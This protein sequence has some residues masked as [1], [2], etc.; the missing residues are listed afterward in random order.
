MAIDYDSWLLIGSG[1]LQERRV[2]ECPHCGSPLS[3]DDEDDFGCCEACHEANHQS[4]MEITLVDPR[5]QPEAQVA[6][7]A[8]KTHGSKSMARNDDAWRPIRTCTVCGEGID[9]GDLCYRHEHK[10]MGS[11]E[12]PK[13]G[14]MMAPSIPP[15]EATPRKKKQA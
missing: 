2:Y 9:D 7:L 4:E 10:M 15:D 1:P 8:D 14:K 13:P 11:D 3:A 5:P 6:K 12:E